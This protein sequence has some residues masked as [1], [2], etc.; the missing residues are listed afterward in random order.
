[1][2]L[3]LVLAV[4]LAGSASAEGS[5][6]PTSAEGWSAPMRL[7]HRPG[8]GVLREAARE[9]AHEK[10]QSLSRCN[11]WR[12]MARQLGE[13]Y[14][15]HAL[16]TSVIRRNCESLLGL[17]NEDA[18]WDWPWVGL[19]QG[20]LTPPRLHRT[21]ATW[22]IRCGAAAFRHRCAAT[23]V[24]PVSRQVEGE[25]SAGASLLVHFVIDMIAGRESVL[26]RVFSPSDGEVSTDSAEPGVGTRYAARSVARDGTHVLRYRLSGREESV[27]FVTCAGPGCIMEADLVRSSET[28]TRLWDGTSIDIEVAMGQSSVGQAT[29]PGAGFREALRELVRLRRE[30][31]KRDAR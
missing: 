13:S 23:A 18:V 22:Q 15:G 19:T 1:V 10:L 12:A 24:V 9:A 27:R 29:I 5:Y 30:E 4:A 20:R 3:W 31:T 8:Q 26:W 11:R 17:R 16:R 7:G 6:R 2:A 28:A 25:P 21:F 14:A